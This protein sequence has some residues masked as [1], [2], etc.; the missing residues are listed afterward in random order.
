MTFTRI[1]DW[2]LIRGVMTHPRLWDAGT[3]DFAPAR[4]AFEPRK[5]DAIW[6]VAVHNDLNV[7]EFLGLFILAPQN[8]ICWE[9][10]TRLLPRAWGAHATEAMRGVIAWGFAALPGCHRIVG[11][12][13]AP[14]KLA[15]RFAERAGFTRYGTNERSYLKNG[16]LLDQVLLGISK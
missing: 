5:D 14:N 15:I 10:H 11:A 3:D 1:R 16:T 6:Y 7:P 2:N 8:P 9:I 13:P 12:V 4:K